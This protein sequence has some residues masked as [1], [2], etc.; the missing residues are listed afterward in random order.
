MVLD[1]LP[2]VHAAYAGG[3]SRQNH[4]NRIRIW[5][6]VNIIRCGAEEIRW[7]AGGEAEWAI[8]RE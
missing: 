4:I 5:G 8:C 6:E 1:E 2:P 7:E 3:P